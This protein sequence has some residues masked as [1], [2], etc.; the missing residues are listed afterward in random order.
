MSECPFCKVKVGATDFQSSAEGICPACGN[1]LVSP[2]PPQ[3]LG[4][5]PVVEDDHEPLSL[6]DRVRNIDLGSALAFLCFGVAL[7]FI[8]F[9]QLE[10]FIKPMAALGLLAG[11]LGGVLPAWRRSGNAILPFLMSILCLL[12]LLFVG[13]WPSSSPSSPP[14]VVVPLKQ[15]GMAAHQAVSAD[16][17]VDASANAVK[18]GDVRVEIVSVQIGPVSLKRNGSVG[19][20]AEP[21]LSIRLRASYG[22]VIFQQTPYQPWADLADSPS[23]Q[24]P[25][26]TDDQGRTYAQK[27]FDPGSKV[28]GRADVDALNPGHQVKEVLVYPIPAGDVKQLR[29]LLPASAFGLSGEFRFQI[30]RNMIHGQ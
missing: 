10:P 5:A 4:T 9:Y 8:S 24:A 19:A 13:K 26:L 28:V 11:L 27:T 20:S 3:P 16:D 30:P 22:G 25:T 17:W 7:L 12:V 23:K 6:L 1:R 2:T 18:R 14:L 21:Y 15:K 29:L